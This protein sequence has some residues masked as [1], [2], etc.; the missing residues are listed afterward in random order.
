M[1]TSVFVQLQI[2]LKLFLIKI[3]SKDIKR[4][5]EIFEKESTNLEEVEAPIQKKIKL[6]TKEKRKFQYELIKKEINL[7]RKVRI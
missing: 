4:K 3:M 6:D 1:T 2:K 7:N 5:R